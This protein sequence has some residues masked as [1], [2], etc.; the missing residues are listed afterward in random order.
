[1]R[2]P[3]GDRPCQH[4]PIVQGHL[5][6]IHDWCTCVRERGDVQFVGGPLQNQEG[7]K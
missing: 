4:M 1:M 7:R 5:P 6:S 2:E 3:K